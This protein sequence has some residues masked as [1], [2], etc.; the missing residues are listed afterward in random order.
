MAPLDPKA[1]DP[2]AGSFDSL[3][4]LTGLAPTDVPPGH[5]VD[6]PQIQAALHLIRQF[7]HSEMLGLADITSLDISVPQIIQL[8]TG[9]G[10]TITFCTDRD[11]RL[12]TQLGRW[13]RVHDF[14]V[15]KGK[16]IATLDLSVTNYI[17]ARWF[18]AS[19]LPPVHPKLPKSSLYKKKHV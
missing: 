2:S 12:E 11:I 13:R 9:Q 19:A 10:A 17:P 6:N 5:R 16:A 14:A 18:E 3:P 1:I 4:M 8:T 7:G 15:E